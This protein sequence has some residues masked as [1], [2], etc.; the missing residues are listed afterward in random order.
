MEPVRLL[1]P[2]SPFPAKRHKTVCR[3]RF[4]HHYRHP[5]Y[6]EWLE[7]THEV[8]GEHWNSIHKFCAGQFLAMNMLFLVK[9]PKTSKLHYPTLDVDNAAKAIMD[10][11]N[12][13]FYDDDKQV[14]QIRARKAWDRVGGDGCVLIEFKEEVPAPQA[15]L[16]IIDGGG[17]TCEQVITVARWIAFGEPYV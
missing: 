9:K 2:V 7:N 14:T 3:G 11:G 16:P 12:G 13:L 17:L 6:T 1:L 15:E 10:A 5:K 4:P 8:I